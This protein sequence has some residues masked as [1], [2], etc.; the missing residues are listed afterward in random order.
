VSQIGLLTAFHSSS[1]PR[2]SIP[3][4]TPWTAGG[5]NG[6]AC[7]CILIITLGLFLL[8]LTNDFYSFMA[9]AVISGFGNGL[10]AG[11]TRRWA[12]T[13]R[14]RD[15]EASSSASGE[16][17]A[18]TGAAGG[19]LFVSLLTGLSGLALASLASGGIGLIGAALLILV[20]PETLKR[21]A[22]LQV[23]PIGPPVA[24][25]EADPAG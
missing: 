18:D 10:G 13:S 20:V 22:I 11:I 19:P 5:A 24:E 2:S 6:P 17:L 23:D 15:G 25:A 8:P 21:P 9:I 4:D 16:W 12:L 1:T 3:P 7:H 14:L